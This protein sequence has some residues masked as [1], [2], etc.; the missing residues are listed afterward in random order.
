MDPAPPR[1]EEERHLLEQRVQA[2]REARRAE[3]TQRISP[4]ELMRLQEL[5]FMHCP[6]CGQVLKEVEAYGIRIDLCP[7]CEGLWLDRGELDQILRRAGGLMAF[8][9]SLFGEGAAP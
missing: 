5:H 1:S 4:D 9:K 6:K 7:R 3:F 2:L 8:F